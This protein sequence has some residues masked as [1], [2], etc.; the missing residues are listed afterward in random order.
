MSDMT[1]NI[2]TGES[3][4]PSQITTSTYSQDQMGGNVKRG[5]QCFCVC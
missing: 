1:T 5:L 3:N 4:G 2:M